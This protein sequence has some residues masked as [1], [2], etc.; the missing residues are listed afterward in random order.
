MRNAVFALIVSLGLLP[1]ARVVR[2]AN[3]PLDFNRDI[4]P[5]LSDNCFNCHGPDEKKRKAKLRLDVRDVAIA[6]RDGV[7][8]IK[9]KDLKHSELWRRVTTKDADDLMPPPDSNKKLTAQQIDTLRRWILE[10]AE[11]KGHW[12]FEAPKK[13]QLPKVKN[14]RW[15][16]NEIDYF[17]AAKLDENK[18]KPE[19]EADKETLIRRVSFDLTG[20]PPTPEEV[21]AFLADKSPDAYEKLIDRL[22][23]S[24]RYGEHQARYWLDAVRYGDTHGLHLDNERSMWPYRD[25]VVEAFNRNMPF[26]QF[27]IWQIAGD[28]LPNATREQKVA[29]GYNR[30]NVTTSEGGAIDEEFYVRYAID[31]TETTCVNW[32]GLTAGCAVCHDHKFDPISQKEFYSLYWFFNNNNEKAMDGN[33]L[34]TPPTIKLP[35]AEEQKQLDDYDRQLADAKKEIADTLAQAKLNYKDPGPKKFEE[36]AAAREV[37]YVEDQFPAGVKAQKI[38]GT[39]DLLWTNANGGPVFSGTNAIKRTATGLAQ[40]FFQDASTSLIVGGSNDTFFAYV[41]ID[42]A[43]P[44]KAIMLQYHT[45]E[46]LYR[47]NWGDADAIPFGEKGKESKLL[48]GD[49]PKAGEWVRLEIPADRFKMKPGLR[50][51]G[52]A[53]VQFGGTVY[54]DKAG[55]VTKMDQTDHSSESLMA[56]E[57]HVKAQD[58]AGLPS[59]I[60]RIVKEKSAR[61]TDAEKKTLRDYYIENVYAGAKN[62]LGPLREKLKPLQT[63]RDELESKVAATLV[64]EEMPK[65]RGA[66]VLK[67][68]E[69]DKRGDEVQPTVPKFLPPLPATDKTN[70]L[71]LAKWL[72][73][74]EHPLTSRVIVNRYWQQFFG[75]GLVKTAQDFGS[76]GEWPSHPELLDWLAVHFRESGWDIKAFQKLLLTSAAYRQSSHV[77]SKKVEV[78]PENRLVSRG[79]RFRLDAEEIRDNALYL[80]GLLIEKR[81]GHGVRP[82]Q[83]EGI[84]EAVGYTASNTARYTQEHGESLYRRSLYTF[85]KRTAPPP[86]MTTFDAPSREKYCV[87][88]ERTDTPLQALVTMNDVQFVEAARHF[89]ERMIKYSGDAEHRLEFGFRSATAR[90]PSTS[91]QMVLK[92]TLSKHL[93]KYTAD[94]T[95]AQKLIA[96]G[97]APASKD[98]DASELAAYTMVASL[99]LN[100]DET[101]NRN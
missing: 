14:T 81:G 69:Y 41:Y 11:Y 18:L 91:E 25:W 28:L 99:L 68:G 27:T 65:P 76:Q 60:A 20:L 88:R 15:P 37:V 8:A 83:P 26:D 34:L 32:M 66:Y 53:F 61:L 86:A 10:G 84:W 73:A 98:A 63:K 16:K 38:D 72:V 1:S 47:G 96:V 87:R 36:Q 56:W 50:V 33:A 95:A 100:L 17:I 31:R 46:W 71:A 23:Q 85:W 64:M 89:A 97:E 48:M 24:P 78:D 90:P 79:P 7:Q 21:D 92:Q 43:N 30:C 9:P 4:R 75:T 62:S 40:D 3:K 57:R 39:P 12:A 45:T 58:A 67:R 80:A 101:L 35:T 74:P 51:N 29:S 19:Q 44:P 13:P 59:E 6:D 93:A 55:L 54:W 49:L 70:R 94:K 22:M 2:A 42:P 82:Y 52:V 77:T 5:I